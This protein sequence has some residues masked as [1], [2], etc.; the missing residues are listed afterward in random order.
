[1]KTSSIV[2]I[3]GLLLAAVLTITAA[4][5]ATAPYLAIIIVIYCVIRWIERNDDKKDNEDNH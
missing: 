4:I 5:Y 1:M 2:L 3:G